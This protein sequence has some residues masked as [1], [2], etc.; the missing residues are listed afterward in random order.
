[1]SKL[2]WIADDVLS[3]AV[4]ALLQKARSAK[5]K[6]NKKFGKNVIDPFSAIFEMSGFNIDYD[7]W[8][9]SEEA[10]QAQKTLQNFVG[11]F[12]QTL[13]GSCK[14]WENLRTGNIVDVVNKK[15]K[16]IAEVKNK[17]NTLS[18]GKLSDLYYSL[19]NAVMPKT[20]IYKGFTA[21]YVT[22][23]PS[24]PDRHNIEFTPSDNKKGEKCPS[25]KLIR[26]ID[27][28]SFYEMVTGEKAALEDLYNILPTVIYEIT[29]V[30]SL[31]SAK[32]KK[33]FE[34]AYGSNED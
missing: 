15:D 27:G 32:L 8:K 1:M 26:Q 31:D 18:G 19:S 16:I 7:D 22:I 28:A 24:K 6:A 3:D 13:L 34:L 10:R 2:T 29:G 17:H 21:Y 23:I 4:D 20:S 5:A 9:K 11:E 14:N 12:H 25:N 33:L 30:D